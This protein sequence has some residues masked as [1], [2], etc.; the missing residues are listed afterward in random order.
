[1]R[2]YDE[3]LRWLYQGGRP[4]RFARWQNRASAVVFGAGI[5]PRRA[6]A[7]EVRGRRSG[8]VISFPVV[9]T[10]YEGERYLVAMLGA[11]TNW[12]LNVRAAAGQ[13]V[14][15]NGRRKAVRLEEVG[16]AARPA[17]L[18]RYLALAPG[19]RAHIPV[20]RHAPPGEFEKIAG[21]FPVFRITAATP[22]PEPAG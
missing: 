1:M 6:A 7:L 9:I 12:V 15:R 16:T 14:L 17:I 10:G 8:R 2:L 3:Y 11:G 5:W 13:A 22:A 21:Q 4:N 19:A 18:R 20:D